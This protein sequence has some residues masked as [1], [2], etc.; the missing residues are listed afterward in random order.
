LEA[1]QA[2]DKK[3]SSTYRA[4]GG[5]NFEEAFGDLRIFINDRI[6]WL[7]KQFTS[8]DTFVNSLGYYQPSG[9]IQV[10]SVTYQSDG[11]AVITATVTNTSAKYASFEVNG[12]YFYDSAIT[13]GQCSVTVD[14][15]ALTDKE[16]NIVQ[17]RIKDAGGSYITTAGSNNNADSKIALSNYKTF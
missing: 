11:T 12:T 5:K 9:D 7:D 6:D 15:T 16:H 1:A 8:F 4:Y 17:V 2:N 10:S 3:W 13:N 14:S